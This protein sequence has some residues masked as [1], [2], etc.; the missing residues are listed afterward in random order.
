MTRT[1]SLR[2]R[3][4]RA[5][6]AD[7]DWYIEAYLRTAARIRDQHAKPRGPDYERLAEKCQA[8]FDRIVTDLELDDKGRATRKAAEI[9]IN[10]AISDYHCPRTLL[11]NYSG[12]DKE[13][14]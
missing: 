7:V 6:I 4:E 12:E 8:I 2:K 1:T 10:H 5:Q 11:K 3:A 9:A 13:A 14:S